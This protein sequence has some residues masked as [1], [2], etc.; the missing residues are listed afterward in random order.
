MSLTLPCLSRTID[1]LL[2]SFPSSFFLCH[3]PYSCASLLLHFIAFSHSVSP[4]FFFFFF[5]FSFCSSFPFSSYFLPLFLFFFQSFKLFPVVGME[6]VN[7]NLFDMAEIFAVNIACTIFKNGES[8]FQTYQA[9]FK[10]VNTKGIKFNA[11]FIF[12]K[13]FS[14]E[15][16]H[17][18]KLNQL[19]VK[20]DKLGG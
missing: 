1:L 2:L 9:W 17:Q 16:L 13:P 12:S 14:W 6:I 10:L 15:R 3:H 7:G 8:H 20:K 5:S 4:S 11:C 18:I 19:V